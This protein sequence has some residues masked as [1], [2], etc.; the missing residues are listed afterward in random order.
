MQII[1]LIRLWYWNSST[2]CLHWTCSCRYSVPQ[3]R[4]DPAW[5]S[6]GSCHK[7]CA[8]QRFYRLSIPQCPRCLQTLSIYCKQAIFISS[9]YIQCPRNKNNYHISITMSAMTFYITQFLVTKLFL[10]S[11]CSSGGEIVFDRWESMHFCDIC[12]VH[13]I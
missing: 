1:M 3:T 6:L 13:H 5:L 2:Q 7:L 10:Y 11:A 9:I 12:P 4:L 8:M